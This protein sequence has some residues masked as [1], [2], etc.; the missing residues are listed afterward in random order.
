MSPPRAGG[1][2]EIAHRGSGHVTENS[3]ERR[4]CTPR[5]HPAEDRSVRPHWDRREPRRQEAAAVAGGVALLPRWGRRRRDIPVVEGCRGS[6]LSCRGG[7]SS[8]RLGVEPFEPCDQYLNGIDLSR[9]YMLGRP[10]D[11]S[12]VR[13]QVRCDSWKSGARRAI[14]KPLTLRVQQYAIPYGARL[15]DE[16]FVFGLEGD[17]RLALSTGAAGTPVA[18]LTCRSHGTSGPPFPLPGGDPLR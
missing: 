12:D 14:V 11:R 1:D 9:A 15:G 16:P 13:A 5:W 6:G 17:G 7:A 4:F 3:A 8:G 18:E 2:T 10:G